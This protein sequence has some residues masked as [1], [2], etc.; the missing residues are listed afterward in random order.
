MKAQIASAV[1]S[2]VNNNL[3]DALAKIIT[4]TTTGVEKSVDFLKAEIPDVIHQ[5]L[6]WKMLEAALCIGM[7]IFFTIC[8][9]VIFK[10]FVSKSK[11]WEENKRTDPFQDNDW[12]GGAICSGV[13][14]GCVILLSCFVIPQ[15]VATIAK[16]KVAPKVYLIEYAADLLKNKALGEK[17]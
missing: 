6:M 12:F 13:I 14:F 11:W 17:K 16:I 4:T 15:N 7:V 10:W 9:G 2:S 8:A 3:Q 5:L 1:E